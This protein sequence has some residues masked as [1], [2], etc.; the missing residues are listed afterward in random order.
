[1]ARLLL[2]IL[3]ACLGPALR[4]QDAGR[5]PRDDSDLRELISQEKRSPTTAKNVRRRHDALIRFVLRGGKPDRYMP[6]RTGMRIESLIDEGRAAEAAQILHGVILDLGKKRPG[7]GADGEEGFAPSGP[8]GGQ[9]GRSGSGSTRHLDEL[10]RLEKQTPTTEANV[11]AHRHGFVRAMIE[12]GAADRYV[13]PGSMEPIEEFLAQGRGREAAAKLHE[14]ILAA[15]E[16]LAREA[17]GPSSS[18]AVPLLREAARPA[19]NGGEAPLPSAAPAEADRASA[20]ILYF[21]AMQEYADGKLDRALSL[22]QSASKLDP[23]NQ[24]IAKAL[25]RLGKERP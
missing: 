10:V 17:G 14:V 8:G 18:D 5:P 4:A 6:R 11:L 9:R 16:R 1:M 19:Q 22:L 23:S 3:I 7:E 21:K 15:G 12:S 13:S 20:S 25:E 24:D 2:P